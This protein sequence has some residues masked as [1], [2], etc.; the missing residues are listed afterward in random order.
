MPTQALQLSSRPQKSPA[1]RSAAPQRAPFFPRCALS[2]RPSAAHNAGVK[3]GAEPCPPPLP[4]PGAHQ[5]HCRAGG[6]CAGSEPGVRVNPVG[7]RTLIRAACG[8]LRRAGKLQRALGRGTARHRGCLEHAAVRRG[9]GRL[10]RAS[11]N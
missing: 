6:A 3:P 10:P 7:L 2:G 4:P 5:Q 8:R 11:F 1:P 9:L